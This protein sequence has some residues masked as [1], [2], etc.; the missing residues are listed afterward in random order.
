MILVH[1][2]FK[3]VQ[4]GSISDEVIVQ[5]SGA[6]NS[7]LFLRFSIHQLS[8]YKSSGCHAFLSAQQ[9]LFCSRSGI[10]VQ[11]IVD[12]IPILSMFEVFLIVYSSIMYTIRSNDIDL[13][14]AVLK[15]AVAL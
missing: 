10:L 7:R 13:T 12:K 11:G 1:L 8:F 9:I 3:F 14:I 2:N 4:F 15:Y 5:P 6:M